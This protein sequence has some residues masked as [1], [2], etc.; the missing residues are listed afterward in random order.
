MKDIPYQDRT[1]SVQEK[2]RLLEAA[3]RAG[4]L[5]V[6]MSLS[7]SAKDTL[8]FERHLQAKLPKPVVS[9]DHFTAVKD[10]PKAW[11]DWARGWKNCQSISLF[12]TV[13]IERSG[14]PV[15]LA[16]AFPCDHSTDLGREL[17]VARVD[18][19]GGTLKEVPCQ[20]HAEVR[21][22][23]ERHCRLVVQADVPAHQQA[24][25]LVFYDNVL[26]ER[27]GHST[28]LHTRGEGYALDIE[29]DYFTAR[30]SHQE[31]QLERLIYKRQH[32]LELYAG[33]KGHGEPPGIDW[34]HD[35]VD[36]GHFQKLRMRNWASCPNYEVVRGPLCTRVRRWGFPHSPLHPVFTPSRVHMEQTYIFHAGLP[37]FFKEGRMDV[38]KDVTIEAIRDDEWVFSGYSFTDTLWFDR[39]GKLHEGTVPKESA[40]DLWG[41][42][43]YNRQSHD[44]FV[45]LW[46]EHAA[47][48]FDGLTHGGVPTLH[49]DG[50]GQLW[51][52]YP[53]NHA[54]L[55]AGTS[56]RQKN[57]YLVSP[58][59][60]QDATAKLERL[61]HQLLNP[62]D[63][64]AAELPRAAANG[65]R[66]ALA[67]PG[68]NAETAPN[69][70]AIWKA[71]GEVRDEQLYNI[72]ANIVDMGYV[73][74]VSEHDGIV[75]VLV[76]MPHRGRPEYNFLVT[77]G[78]GRVEPGIRERLLKLK[79]VREVIVDFTW[80]PP[81]TVS[82]LTDAGRRALGLPD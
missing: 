35:Y 63:A 22:G 56:I 36:S 18:A 13:G 51:S 75:T 78:G 55:K 59:E 69:K 53:A 76:T 16:L 66:G 33:G 27:P 65:A 30:L 47:E 43:F 21:R 82:R 68:E 60:G 29:N 10:L 19:G 50:H 23:K 1:D 9:P 26:A 58:F 67:K 6:A 80:N 64:H 57:A 24:T 11:A 14:E 3:Y 42:G 61:R 7:E 20:V 8:T 73:Y 62:L 49:Y 38:V 37:Y 72:D 54:M 39:R 45:A 5:D 81:W 25:Y 41:V 17:R 34:A 79:G 52:R 31:G 32:G 12:E 71:L 48:G 70:P 15:D 46:L 4:K 44:A 28:D 40:E 77:A 2:L 74:D